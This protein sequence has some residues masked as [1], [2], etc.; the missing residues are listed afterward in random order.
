[1]LILVLSKW[2]S[3]YPYSQQV[4]YSYITSH[5]LRFINC[6]LYNRG[7]PKERSQEG[8]L[9]Q[10][11]IQRIILVNMQRI[12][13]WWYLYYYH[14]WPLKGLGVLSE[15]MEGRTEKP[16]FRQECQVMLRSR[17]H[18][19]CTMSYNY[20]QLSQIWLYSFLIWT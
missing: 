5:L 13:D 18:C 16:G 6:P 10:W 2:S 3:K 4:I 14:H 1:M 8:A 7:V 17:Y 9:Q 11:L 15:E 19:H 12:S 20:R